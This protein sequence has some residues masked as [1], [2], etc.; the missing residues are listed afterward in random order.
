MR[1]EEL[2]VLTEH[3]KDI[4]AKTIMLRIADD[5]DRL[6]RLAEENNGPAK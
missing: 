2:R 4:E 5:N 6:A 3:M 1:A